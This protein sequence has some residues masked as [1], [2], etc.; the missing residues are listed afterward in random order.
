M[1]KKFIVCLVWMACFCLSAEAQ[2]AASVLRELLDLPSP[3][4]ASKTVENKRPESFYDDKNPPADDAPI[5]DLRDYWAFIANAIYISDETRPTASVKASLRLIEA[6]DDKSSNI[7]NLLKIVPKDKEIIEAIKQLF[8][9]R[10]AGDNTSDYERERVKTWLMDN[11][12][13]FID[14]VYAAALKAKDDPEYYGIIYGA[15]LKSLVRHDWERAAELLGKLERD[16][17][18]PRTAAVAKRFFY[19][20]ALAEKNSADIEKYRGELQKIVENKQAAGG[21]RDIAFDALAQNAAWQ[22]FDDWYVAQFADETLLELRLSSNAISTPLLGVTNKDPDKWIPVLTKLV[23]NRD[24]NIHNAAVNGLFEIAKAKARKDAITPLLPWLTKPDWAKDSGSDREQLIR[25]L[26]DVEMPE[27]VPDLL[28]ILENDADNR[29]YALPALAHYKASQ[30]IP[31]LRRILFET[32]EE[33]TR[34]SYVSALIACGGFTDAELVEALRVYVEAILTADGYKAVEERD[35]W[36]TENPLPV[37]ISTGRFAA[38]QKTPGES[39][40]RALF[41]RIKTL[42]ETN[43]AVTQKLL[44]IANKWQG[45]AVETEILKRLAEG[46]AEVNTILTV[47]ARRKELRESAPLELSWLTARSGVARAVGVAMLEDESQAAS[48]VRQT[49]TETQIAMLACARLLRL[50]LPVREV[51]ALLDSPDKLLALAAERYLESEDSR[52][53]RELVL[54]RHRGEA[55]ILGARDAFN[56]LKKYFTK[57]YTSDGS[58]FNETPL[59]KLFLSVNGSYL[60]PQN[61][62]GFNQEYD[63]AE[64]KLRKEILDHK[65]LKEIYAAGRNQLRVFKDKAVFTWYTDDAFYRE[66][67]LTKEELEGFYDYLIEKKIDEMSS[68]IV[69]VHN[70]GPSQFVMLSR[71][72][73]RRVF[74]YDGWGTS[75]ALSS[76]FWKLQTEDAEFH[77]HLEKSV[78]GLKV[79]AVDKS[80][81]AQTL[82][83]NGDD[84]RVLSADRSRQ[85]EIQSELSKQD[86]ADRKTEEMTNKEREEMRNKRSAER[87]FEHFSWLSFKDGKYAQGAP[88][89]MGV[90][91]FR[92][93][94][95]MPYIRELSCDTDN[96]ESRS[97]LFQLC[98]GTG[99]QDGLWRV[100]RS[101][102]LRIRGGNYKSPIVT[103]DGRWVIASKFNADWDSPNA[104]VRIDLETGKELKI[105]LAPA[106]NLSAVAF[107]AAHS[108]I[109][110]RSAG[111]SSADVNAKYYLLDAETGAVSPVKGVF[112]PLR[113]QFYRALQSTGRPN[114]FWAAV[115]DGKATEIGIYETKTF[116]FK[117]LVRLDLIR[118]R[119]SNIWVDEK[120]GKIYFTYG[121]DYQENGFL[122][123][124]PLPPLK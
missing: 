6:Y 119:S 84:F 86:E 48:L 11:S 82:W 118:L 111:D 37:Q 77:F 102:K 113:N 3:P 34:E 65:E 72:G 58:S 79:L 57:I 115:Y 56:P 45:K 76:M 23:G 97:L 26:E 89:P 38:R 80:I 67:A 93:L 69:C 83:K 63:E 19:E 81:R 87:R 66:K 44:E 14:E 40:V 104:V 33:V 78:P 52:E 108:K 7:T 123:S 12:D 20:R 41:E 99:E 25:R 42:Q 98:T 59:E 101:E 51:G 107:V 68:S 43:P 49:D 88:E 8:D 116:S 30:A 27:V 70:C 13:F 53:A 124:I 15:Q 100:N 106:E 109:L 17:T 2:A 110:L 35:R 91:F 9:T 103:P 121:D 18:N 28:W 75:L 24:P 36:Q 114:E 32:P 120:D 90:P 74:A 50:K 5:D 95:L 21:A 46:R 22:G 96:L 16:P 71:D 39:F 64:A 47:L 10:L 94:Q 29:E 105:N 122:L 55:L 112:A 85:L 73:G 117:P 31:M 61:Y 92:D 4:P 54:A 1:S 62:Y 60:F